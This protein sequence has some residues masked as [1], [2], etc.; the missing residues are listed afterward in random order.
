MR[1]EL[2]AL[3]EIVA[4]A[5]R[6][7]PYVLRTPIVSGGVGAVCLKLESLQRSGSFKLR[8]AFNSL[9]QLSEEHRVRG[10]VAHSSGNHAVAVAMAAAD[11]SIP[12]TVVMPVDAPLR[13][14]DWVSSLGATVELVGSDS[15][16]RSTCAKELAERF[17]LALIEPYDSPEIV[18]ATG[19]IGLEILGA[20]APSVWSAAEV[21]VPISGGGLIAGIAAAIKLRD[22]SVRIVGV[23]PEYAADVAASLV[24]G[25]RVALAAEDVARTIA[26]GLRVQCVGTIPWQHILQY[27]DEVVT[28]SEAQIYEAMRRL[29]FDTRVVAEPSGAVAPAAAFA[30]D[31]CGGPKVAVVS[32]GNVDSD[33]L[34]RVL[35]GELQ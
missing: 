25:Q 19:V 35:S 9:L 1:R 2:V 31:D 8:G 21:Y 3:D 27:V 10:V 7:G 20:L 13:K 24:V 23:E 18:S 11:L 26:D 22:P 28:V 12:A 29:V 17:S 32:G 4:A 33:L 5:R 16:E 15:S 14:R 6:T 30:S 34:A